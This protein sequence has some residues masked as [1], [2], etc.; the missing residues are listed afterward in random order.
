MIST[1]PEARSCLN[2][3]GGNLRRKD[4]RPQDLFILL[5]PDYKRG[6]VLGNQLGMEQMAL[7]R[8]STVDLPILMMVMMMIMFFLR[9]GFSV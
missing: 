4:R 1:T 5:S 9:Q 2:K 3:L 7:S 8:S 6:C